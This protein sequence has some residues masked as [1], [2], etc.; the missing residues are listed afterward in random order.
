MC[1]ESFLVRVID[2]INVKYKDQKDKLTPSHL[3]RVIENL[4]P[5]KYF[6][7]FLKMFQI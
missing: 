2:G 4:D 1:L 6:Q 7:M 5:K 3:K